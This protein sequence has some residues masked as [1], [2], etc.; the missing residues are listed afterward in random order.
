MPQI[1]PR[2]AGIWAKQLDNMIIVIVVMMNLAI[3]TELVVVTEIRL[4][5]AHTAEQEP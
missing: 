3:P 4:A 1:R 2:S 5:T